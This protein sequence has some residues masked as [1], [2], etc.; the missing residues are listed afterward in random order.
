[1]TMSEKKLKV[2]VT[3]GAGFIGSNAVDALIAEGYEV[4]VIDDP[5]KPPLPSQKR[6]KLLTAH[7]YNRHKKRLRYPREQ[8]L[9]IQRNS[10]NLQNR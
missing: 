9:R 10:A 3:G 8:S 4:H 7:H 2:I 1:M 5:R 6:T